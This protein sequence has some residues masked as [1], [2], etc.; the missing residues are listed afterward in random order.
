MHSRSPHWW[1]PPLPASP[2]SQS[3]L[4]AQCLQCQHQDILLQAREHEVWNPFDLAISV[5]SKG[6]SSSSRPRAV[7]QRIAQLWSVEQ[8]VQN[9]KENKRERIGLFVG[10]SCIPALRAKSSKPGMRTNSC[11]DGKL[12]TCAKNARRSRALPKLVETVLNIGERGVVR[13]R[14]RTNSTM[15]DATMAKGMLER[16]HKMNGILKQNAKNYIRGGNKGTPD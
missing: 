4:D 9:Q 15:Q 16:Y 13:N 6:F 3:Q 7:Q 11:D 1:S 5:V 8:R 2:C 14:V 12:K 10:Y